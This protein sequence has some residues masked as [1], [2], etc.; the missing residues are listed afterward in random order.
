M[1]YSLCKKLQKICLSERLLQL[2]HNDPGLKLLDSIKKCNIIFRIEEPQISN[3]VQNLVL[4]TNETGVGVNYNM[5]DFG[6]FEKLL[7]ALKY[8]TDECADFKLPSLSKKVYSSFTTTLCKYIC[9]ITGTDSVI[10]FLDHIKPFG[11]FCLDKDVL[12]D[13]QPLNRIE[14][15]ILVNG[16]VHIHDNIPLVLPLEKICNLNNIDNYACP[17]P[18]FCIVGPMPG[19]FGE[20]INRFSHQINDVYD[21]QST[22]ESTKNILAM[23]SNENLTSV[24]ASAY[25]KYYTNLP[26]GM[27]FYIGTPQM[28]SYG[29]LKE[30]NKQILSYQD[31]PLVSHLTYTVGT[32]LLGYIYPE[33]VTFQYDQIKQKDGSYSLYFYSYSYTCQN[34][35]MWETFT[36]MQ[37]LT[38]KDECSPTTIE[39]DE[40][41]PLINF[42]DRLYQN[43]TDGIDSHINEVKQNIARIED[44]SMGSNI[45]RETEQLKALKRQKQNMIDAKRTLGAQNIL[46]HDT[47]EEKIKLQ[48]D[49]INL[50]DKYVNCITDND[51]DVSKLSNLEIQ[52]KEVIGDITSKQKYGGAFYEVSS[53]WLKNPHNVELI[54]SVVEKIHKMNISLLLKYQN[55]LVIILRD[56]YNAMEFTG[57]PDSYAKLYIKIQYLK[58]EDSEEANEPAE[59]P[60]EKEESDSSHKETKQLSATKAP[61]SSTTY[62]EPIDS[63]AITTREN[64]SKNIGTD[65]LFDTSTQN[66]SYEDSD[67]ITFSSKNITNRIPLKSKL[68]PN[69]KNDNSKKMK[70]VEVQDIKSTL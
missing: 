45:D 30:C 64:M 12:V 65:K 18:I 36:K 66:N 59:K 10:H 5:Y 29:A 70:L 34:E 47:H 48:T 8:T 4:I 16:N 14:S 23:Y 11:V 55:K 25:P 3:Y 60:E 21:F 61:S 40:K 53:T 37:L 52:M 38:D 69:K 67:R 7:D 24:L 57:L 43:I 39:A 58:S 68:K 2:S 51:C 19:I 63:P 42:S 27:G 33:G 6:S 46:L 13:L 26:Y 31:F 56:I 49:L 20:N 35:W 41:E 1:E 62:E 50:L 9:I 22:I 17:L 32:I 15:T 44:S 28:T 54:E